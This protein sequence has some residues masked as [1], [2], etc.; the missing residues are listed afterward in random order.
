MKATKS[1]VNKISKYLWKK[2][3]GSKGKLATQLGF[4]QSEITRLLREGTI[5]EEKLSKI[6]DIVN[7]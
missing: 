4:E 5:S 3:H 2:G 6:L 7:G 1:Q